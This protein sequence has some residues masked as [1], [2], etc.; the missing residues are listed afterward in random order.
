MVKKCTALILNLIFVGVLLL[1]SSCQTSDSP[2]VLVIA[3]DGLSSAESICHRESSQLQKSGFGELCAESVRAT[4]AYTTSTL[5]VP[6]LTSLLTGLYPFQSHVRFN[7]PPGLKSEIQTVTEVAEGRGYQTAFFSGQIAHSRR[8]GL[9]QGFELF[10][11]MINHE[12]QLAFRPIKETYKIFLDWLNES[13]AAKP[14]FAVLTVADLLFPEYQTTN[15]LGETRSQTYDSQLEEID[16][17]LFEVIQ[18]L[19]KKKMWDKTYVILTGL[20][21]KPQG[22][23]SQNYSQYL[24]LHSENTQVSLLMKPTYGEK[25]VKSQRTFDPSISLADVGRTLFDLVKSSFI[26]NRQTSFPVVSLEAVLKKTAGPW[27]VQRLIPIEA[28]WLSW[29]GLG[30]IRWAA[31]NQHE[32]YI[33]DKRIQAYNTLTDRLEKNPSFIASL[34][35]MKNTFPPEAVNE[36]E[37]QLWRWPEKLPKNLNEYYKTTQPKLSWTENSCLKWAIMQ[38]SA[39]LKKECRNSDFQTYM[40]WRM[41]QEKSSEKDLLKDQFLRKMRHRNLLKKFHEL[42]ISLDGP[43]E[44]LAYSFVPNDELDEILALNTKTQEMVQDYLKKIEIKKKNNSDD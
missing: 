12:K 2:N 30:P 20:N 28:P 29:Q 24:N 42:N 38:K 16:D 40:E 7:S 11:D 22:E 1:L 8:T 4:H 36:I 13:S 17:A 5:S 31:M 18:N 15:R 34:D 6:S 19:K 3:V 14:F 9:H 43:W 44:P 41:S 25:D 33:F 21:G 37:L 26:E 32:L 39:S 10:D 27:T 35:D 23:H